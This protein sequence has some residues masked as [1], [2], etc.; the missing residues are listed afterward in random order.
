LVAEQFS[1]GSEVRHS[2][3]AVELREDGIVGNVQGLAAPQVLVAHLGSA[4]A[5]NLLREGDV[6]T[7]HKPKQTVNKFFKMWL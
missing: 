1:H 6:S 7:L 5:L 2:N 3:K 4:L